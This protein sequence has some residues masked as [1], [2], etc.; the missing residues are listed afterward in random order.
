MRQIG[1]VWWGELRRCVERFRRR[2]RRCGGAGCR[3]EAVTATLSGECNVAVP[4]NRRKFCLFIIIVIII[5]RNI[6]IDID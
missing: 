5:G 6:D 1:M 4:K 3:G 2:G